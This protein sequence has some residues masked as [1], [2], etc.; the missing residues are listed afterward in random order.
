MAS[1]HARCVGLLHSERPT[2]HTKI[3]I[4]RMECTKFYINDFLYTSLEFL[5][6]WKLTEA[7]A[8]TREH[9]KCLDECL[10]GKAEM[11]CLRRR[12]LVNVLYRLVYPRW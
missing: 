2:S 7:A 6:P 10:D 8:Y 9:G 11:R 4:I 5:L 1:A 3:T 12:L